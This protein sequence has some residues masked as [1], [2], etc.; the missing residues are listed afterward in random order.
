MPSPG[1]DHHHQ[2]MPGGHHLGQ[3]A[4]SCQAGTKGGWGWAGAGYRAGC[5]RGCPLK[6]I[7][8]DDVSGWPWEKMRDPSRKTASLK[9]NFNRPLLS[10]R[11]GP[12]LNNSPGDPEA[13]TAPLATVL[14]K[15]PS[16]AMKASPGRRSEDFCLPSEREHPR[17]RPLVGR[18]IHLSCEQMRLTLQKHSF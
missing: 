5:S 4:A 11:S 12:E 17:Q 7:S 15:G 6:G 1:D 8:Y 2:P 14:H 16:D 13:P 9:A 3:M 10:W 18:G